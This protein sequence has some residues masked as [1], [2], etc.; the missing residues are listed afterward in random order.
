[1][2]GEREKIVLVLH[3]SPKRSA[4]AWEPFRVY[5]SK[6]LDVPEEDVVLAYLQFGE[7]DVESAL[8]QCLKDGA[9]RVIL[10]PLFLSAGVHVTKDLPELVEKVKADFPWAEVLI[11]KPLGQHERLA[12]IVKERIDEVRTYSPQSIEEE[13]FRIIERDF[14]FSRFLPLE[15]EVVKRVV[16]ATADPEY[17]E[18]MVFHPKAIEL[19]LKNLRD[20]K[21]ILVDVEM[22][23]AGI[24]KRL[25]PRE[26]VVCYLDRVGEVSIGTRTEQAVELALKNENDLGLVVIGN[27]PTALVRSIEVLREQ[28]RDD[29]VV[30]GLPVGFVKALSAKLMLLREDIPYI[31]NLSRKGGSPAACAVVNALLRYIL[32]STF[33]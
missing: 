21:K 16:H 31:T 13:S 32:S 6:I 4:N 15:R 30:V 9:K 10:H 25:Y 23:K 7:P 29:V 12:E 5:L 20:K 2:K 28:K 18:T 24:S 19:A 33:S 11:T 17:I 3:G 27:S 26:K 14:D 8:R 22:T 1:M